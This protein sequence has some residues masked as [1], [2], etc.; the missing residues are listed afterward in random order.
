MSRER[1]VRRVAATAAAYGG[2]GF[3]LLGVGIAGLLLAEAKLAEI[4]LNVL[5]GEPPR[6]DGIHGRQFARDGAPPLAMTVLGDSTAAGFGVDR[7]DYTP[8]ALLAGGIAAVAERPVRLT[9]VA[10]NGAT[11]RDLERQWQ[12]ALEAEPHPDIALV[13]IGAN[14]I[15]QLVKPADSARFLGD[16]V[17][18]LR[19]AGAEV[20]VGTCPDLGAV[21]GIL[22]PL[23][24]LAR[25]AS[26]QLAAAQRAAVLQARGRSVPLGTLLGPEFVGRPEMFASDRY[27]PSARGYLAASMALL[28]A[29]CAALDLWPHH[30]LQ[31]QADGEPLPPAARES[32]L[33]AAAA[34]LGLAAG[35]TG[36]WTLPKHSSRR[37]PV[38][39]GVALPGRSEPAA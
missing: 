24:T 26:H 25:R 11:S 22:P 39:P 2:G 5:Q 37:R 14:D 4:Q 1:M 8:G 12:V 36:R 7:A 30:D 19:D 23:R 3:G 21:D 33:G 10:V 34:R 9:V 20:V 32:T 18:R 38:E 17:R 15:A 6:A 29:M 35:P 27:H 31:P 28:P 13:M 16:T